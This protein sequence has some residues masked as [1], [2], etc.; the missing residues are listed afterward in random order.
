M[1]W[2]KAF[3]LLHRKRNRRNFAHK[4]KD[5]KHIIGVKPKR[6]GNKMKRYTEEQI[7][8]LAPNEIFVFW[9]QHPRLSWRRC[10]TRGTQQVWCGMGTR[11][12]TAR[13]K[14]CHPDNGRRSRNNTPICRQVHWLC[15]QAPRV[16]ILSY[17]DWLWHCRFYRW[18]YCPIVSKRNR[19]NQH[20]STQDIC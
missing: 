2:E 4:I 20:R 15:K 11:R 12:R 17:K 18:G 1:S 13:S 16:H 19:T 14:L 10:R 7:T 9:Q 5:L 3:K 8:T 6:K